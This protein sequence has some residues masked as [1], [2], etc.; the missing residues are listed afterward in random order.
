MNEPLFYNSFTYSKEMAKETANHLYLQTKLMKIVY[1]TL[2][3][4]AV[5]FMVWP[6]IKD[7]LVELREI[8]S[9]MMPFFYVCWIVS[10]VSFSLSYLLGITRGSKKQADAMC[11]I[12][13]SENEVKWKQGEK[14]KTYN[15]KK[16]YAF[17]ETE[18]Y[19]VVAAGLN[20]SE[21]IYK[22]DAFSVGNSEEFV[23]FLKKNGAHQIK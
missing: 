8:Y 4:E 18:N 10:V 12:T 5:F 6:L 21:M 22:K 13:I 2:A 20:T 17:Y 23:E 15:P 14:T 1:A 9:F 3:L 16:I 7:A 11:I 19:I